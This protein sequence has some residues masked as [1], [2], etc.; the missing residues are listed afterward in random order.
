V[1][2]R[3]DGIIKTGEKWARFWDEV[4]DWRVFVFEKWDSIDQEVDF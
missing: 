1:R 2:E 4:F 3:W